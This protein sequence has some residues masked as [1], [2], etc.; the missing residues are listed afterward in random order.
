MSHDSGF[1]RNDHDST[2]QPAMRQRRRA[3]ASQIYEE[4]LKRRHT[5][6][7][8]ARELAQETTPPPEE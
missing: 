3:K 8:R 2:H 7:D 6:H 5:Q 4:R 1:R